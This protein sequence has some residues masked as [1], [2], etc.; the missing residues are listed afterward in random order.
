MNLVSHATTEA[1]LARHGSTAE[2]RRAAREELVEE[3]VQRARHEARLLG[4][5]L[6]C[7][8]DVRFATPLTSH[9]CRN[10]GSTC[11]CACHDPQPKP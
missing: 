7:E 5:S 4:L 11:L 8:D 1:L 10:D 9:R 2:G 3:A 6:N